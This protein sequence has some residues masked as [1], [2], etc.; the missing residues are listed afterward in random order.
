MWQSLY[1]PNAVFPIKKDKVNITN[2]QTMSEAVFVEKP[3]T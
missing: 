1:H 2:Q 3:K